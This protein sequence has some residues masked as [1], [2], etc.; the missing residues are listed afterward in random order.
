MH[1][2]S[3]VTPLHLPR[4]NG[5]RELI[6]ITNHYKNAIINFSS[7]LLNS[8]EQFLK[9]TSN[10]Q[11]TQGE[12]SNHQ[13]AQRCCDEI[14]HDIQQLA[15]M[16]EIAAEIHF[17]IRTHQQTGGGTQKKEYAWAIY[18]ITWATSCRQRAI[19]PMDKIF[20]PKRST[21]STVTTIQKQAIST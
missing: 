18:I 17:Q 10:R 5:G 21:E 9:L 4:K 12:K 19:Q 3:D 20:Y 8:E 6:N 11:V 1:N 13:K 16:G 15:A 2:Q 7:Y 14:G